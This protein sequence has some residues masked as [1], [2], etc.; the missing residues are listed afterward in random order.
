MGA[1]QPFSRVI[2]Q[3]Y[4]SCDD[5]PRA[6]ALQVSTDNTNWTPLAAASGSTPVTA[7]AF[8]STTA[9]YIKLTQTGMTPVF[10]WSIDELDVYR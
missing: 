4:L 10:Y 3:N 7:I 8:P 1:S 9:R 5:Y 6:Y 2:L